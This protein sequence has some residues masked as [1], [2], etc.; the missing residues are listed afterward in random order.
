MVIVLDYLVI[1]YTK[2]QPLKGPTFAAVFHTFTNI[3]TYLR[4]LLYTDKKVLDSTRSAS[5]LNG[6]Q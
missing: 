4:N 6:A 1:R 3:V 2:V 5:P